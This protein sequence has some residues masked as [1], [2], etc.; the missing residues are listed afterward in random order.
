MRRQKVKEGEGIERTGH[1]SLGH[2]TGYPLSM[3]QPRLQMA[4]RAISIELLAEEAKVVLFFV[5]LKYDVLII[6]A[7]QTLPIVMVGILVRQ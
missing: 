7:Y 6:H 3:L 1:G 2:A 5:I 4:A